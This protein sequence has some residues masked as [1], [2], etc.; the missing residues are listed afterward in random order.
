MALDARACSVSG[1]IRRRAASVAGCGVRCGGT[2]CRWRRRTTSMVV[3]LRDEHGKETMVVL[4]LAS[5]SY[6]LML[7]FYQH[8]SKISVP[9]LC[10]IL[11]GLFCQRSIK[12]IQN[13]QIEV[14]SIKVSNVK[15]MRNLLQI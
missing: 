12:L 13:Y 8:K 3:A 15:D 9:N 1:G 10:Q 5:S 11:F 7:L 6:L 14:K 4:F 2:C